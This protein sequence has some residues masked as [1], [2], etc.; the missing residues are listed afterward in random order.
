M[1]ILNMI[2]LK[3]IILTPDYLDLANS[4][5]FI[6]VAFHPVFA[7]L[8]INIGCFLRLPFTGGGPSICSFGFFQI[9]SRQS[10]W[11][12]ISSHM[13]NWFLGTGQRIQNNDRN[14]QRLWRI[15]E[16]AASYRFEIIQ[17]SSSESELSAF[18]AQMK[19]DVREVKPW[20]RFLNPTTRDW[21]RFWDFSVRFIWESFPNQTECLSPECISSFVLM[22]PDDIRHRLG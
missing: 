10:R 2:I 6:D 18:A 9:A 21:N 19:T 7:N 8:P 16:T 5:H 20:F 15:A 3:K 22:T 14:F 13:S 17:N 1:I 4:F 11:M 12:P